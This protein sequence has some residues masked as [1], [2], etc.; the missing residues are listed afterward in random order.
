MIQTK[1][2]LN[3]FFKPS[4]ASKWNSS[5]YLESCGGPSVGTEGAKLSFQIYPGLL[6]RSNL[7]QSW[8]L[9]TQQTNN[10]NRNQT[11]R[12][13]DKTANRQTNLRKEWKQR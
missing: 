1:K 9:K 11:N 3:A 8:K 7:G 10:N 4:F 2:N 13:K 12:C 5:L 6:F